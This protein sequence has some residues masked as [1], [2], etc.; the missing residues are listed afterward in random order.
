MVCQ[1][2]MD[3][4]W[5]SG[6]VGCMVCGGLVGSAYNVWGLCWIDMGCVC[7]V[8]SYYYMCVGDCKRFGLL[9]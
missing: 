9:Q 1:C 7:E 2:E 4:C 5:V 8:G 6:W 3:T